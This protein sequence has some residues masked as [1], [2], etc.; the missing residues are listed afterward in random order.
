MDPYLGTFLTAAGGFI[1]GYLGPYWSKSQEIRALKDNFGEVKRQT[2]DTTKSVKKIEA[3][4]T[5]EEWNRQKHWE[6]KRDI[7]FETARKAAAEIEALQHLF[8][9]YRTEGIIEKDG[10]PPRL[11]ERL[12]IGDKWNEATAALEG[13]HLV[14]TASCR[15]EMM[16]AVGEFGIYM[17]EAADRIIQTKPDSFSAIAEALVPKSMGLAMAIR[18]E[19]QIDKWSA[20]RSNVAIPQPNESPAIP[21]PAP[22]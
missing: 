18:D 11:D 5:G 19:L 10:G 13:M 17:R 9:I 7:L 6:I 12:R 21:D 20:S 1:G 4:I 22:K 2:E 14:V 3:A 16:K 8:A 15:K